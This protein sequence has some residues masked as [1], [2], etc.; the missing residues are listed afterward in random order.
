VLR[1]LSLWADQHDLDLS[2]LDVGPP[3]LEDAYLAITG[4]DS[5][6]N[7]HG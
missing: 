7:H 4:A 6:E 1:D 3:T 5:G 2:G